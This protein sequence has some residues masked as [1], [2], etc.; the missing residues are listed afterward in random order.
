[1]FMHPLSASLALAV[2][3]AGLD[4]ARA[5]AAL[6]HRVPLS[7]HDRVHAVCRYRHP[8]RRRR[9]RSSRP[10]WPR[11]AGRRA[12]RRS[13]SRRRNRPATLRFAS[14]PTVRI[15]GRDIQLDSR[16]SVCGDC[17]KL[18]KDAS[19]TCREWRYQ[20]KWFTSPP[21]GLFV[22]A[23]LS[24][25][26]HDAARDAPRAAGHSRCP[27]NL[28]R[29]FATK[30]A[31]SNP[32]RAAARRSPSKTKRQAAANRSRPAKQRRLLPECGARVRRRH[33]ACTLS[34]ESRRSP[35]GASE[36]ARARASLERR[37]TSTTASL[38]AS[39][40]SPASWRAS[41]A[42]IDLERDC[43]QFLTFGQGL[44]EQRPGLARGDRIRGREGENR[45]VLRSEV[46]GR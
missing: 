10:S 36:G 27:E 28:K 20:G 19:V 4:A 35:E 32:V 13:T 41:H 22:E 29:F 45:R 25:M 39:S 44:R 14:S 34:A 1:M 15:N 18:C 40:R 12:S 23:M 9:W 21:K 38:S 26:A 2:D 46:V 16:E 33:P 5:R 43:C 8:A 31:A 3:S 30:K 7:R 6:E 42:L 11:R 37:E 24:A 17:G